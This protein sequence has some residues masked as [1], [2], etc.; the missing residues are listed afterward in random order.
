VI[1]RKSAV[2]LASA[3]LGACTFTVPIRV[4]APSEREVV[5]TPEPQGILFKAPSALESLE[6]KS[7]STN[8]TVWRIT[9]T[10]VL[11]YGSTTNLP[12]PSSVRY[13]EVPSG[14]TAQVQSTPLVSGE[15]YWVFIR[16]PGYH[17]EAE[18]Q[19]ERTQP[20]VQRD[21]PAFGGSAR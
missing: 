20:T 7:Q 13:G 14:Y 4:S 6:V 19:V 12:S 1:L 15:R 9:A 17:G 18:F 16:G 21:G 5:F 2:L 11:T 3:V 10:V 8:S